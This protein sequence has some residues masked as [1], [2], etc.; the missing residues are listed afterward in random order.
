RGGQAPMLLRLQNEMQMLLYTHAVN[1][2]RAELGLLPINSFWLSGAGALTD[3]V[4]MVTPQT[5][6]LLMPMTLRDAAVCE[7]WDAW[8]QAWRA[9]D[10]KLVVQALERVRQGQGVTL[11]LCGERNAQRFEARPLRLLR[12]ITR[13]LGRTRL[14]PV[15]NDL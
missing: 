1:D 2:A 15:L 9:L 12:R 8:T 13:L 14:Q 7:D 5:A 4:K 10:A 3:E 6:E 11:T